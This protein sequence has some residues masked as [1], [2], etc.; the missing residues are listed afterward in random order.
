[1]KKKDT[2]DE[3]S[4]KFHNFLHF[5]LIVMGP[6]YIRPRQPYTVA[7]ANLFDSNAAVKLTLKCDDESAFQR[8]VR[9][10]IRG[11]S[12]KSH[13]FAVPEISHSRCTF[14]AIDVGGSITVN[15]KVELMFP[16]KTLSIFVLTDKP[17]YKL[18]DEIRLRVVVVDITTRPVK[19]INSV[20]IY[21]EDSDGYSRRRWTQA[22]LRTGMFEAAYQLSSSATVGTWTITVTALDV[23]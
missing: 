14:S 6:T 11:Q 16:T 2:S 8:N 7:L 12:I 20:K 15:H 1:M 19:H 17:V 13:S 3:P 23:S 21:L 18:G 9:L 5:R 4:R 10:V 22:K